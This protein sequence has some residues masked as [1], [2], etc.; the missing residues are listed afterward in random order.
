MGLRLQVAAT[1]PGNAIVL[2]QLARLCVHVQKKLRGVGFI[3]IL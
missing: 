3:A 2:D 1:A